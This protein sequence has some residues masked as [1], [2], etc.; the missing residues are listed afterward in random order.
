MTGALTS[1]EVCVIGRQRG[2]EPSSQSLHEMVRRAGNLPPDAVFGHGG[3]VVDALR[4]LC[5]LAP[6]EP[7]HGEG[8]RP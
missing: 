2:G 6:S 1:G 3:L 4:L 8:V 7:G 5:G